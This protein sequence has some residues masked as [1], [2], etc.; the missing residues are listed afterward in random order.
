MVYLVM[1]KPGQPSQTVR[2]MRVP[3]AGGPSHLLLEA[4]SILNQQCARLPATLCIYSQHNPKQM[5]FFAFDSVTGSKA[6][7]VAAR[8]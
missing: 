3:L 7:I 8:I 1:P 2:I 6:E 4:P 5:R